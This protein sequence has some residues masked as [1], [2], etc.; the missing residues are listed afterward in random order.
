MAEVR[1]LNDCNQLNS[2]SFEGVVIE[3]NTK[4]SL[5]I[6]YHNLFFVKNI[7]HFINEGGN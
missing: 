5:G 6:R 1:Y 3:H 4:V 2:N 7:M